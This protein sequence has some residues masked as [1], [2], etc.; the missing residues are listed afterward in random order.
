VIDSIALTRTQVE[1]QRAYLAKRQSE[2]DA[3]QDEYDRLLARYRELTGSSATSAPAS[4]DP[5][6]KN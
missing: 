1:E 4:N 3:L 5:T 2:R 6:A